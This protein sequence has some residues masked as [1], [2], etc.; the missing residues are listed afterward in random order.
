[1]FSTISS[2]FSNARTQNDGNNIHRKDY[3]YQ[4]KGRG[5][6]GLDGYIR[7]LGR[8]NIK[9]IRQSHCLV[10]Y[11]SR[12][13][14]QIKS[15]HRKENRRGFPGGPGQAQDC[16]GQDPGDSEGQEPNA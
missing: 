5:I 4:D 1:M 8:N 7:Y 6:A 11:G 13:I 9:M 15:G 2:S 12:Q 14:R 3:P 16:P 10:K